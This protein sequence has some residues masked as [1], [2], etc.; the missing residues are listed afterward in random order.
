MQRCADLR[1][2]LIHDDRVERTTNGR[3]RVA[4]LAWDV[5]RRLDAGQGDSIPLLEDLLAFA[6]TV[7]G[8]FLNLEL[9]MP[10]V[11]PATLAALERAG[12]AGPLAI[13]SFDFP[14]LEETRRLDAGVELWLLASKFE[15]V[16]VDRARAIDATCLA[17]EHAAIGPAVVELVAAAG[18]GLVAWT[19]N[20]LVD[21]RRVLALQPVPRAVISNYP[22]RALGVRDELAVSGR[23]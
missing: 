20:E 15:P 19:V 9:K 21:L 5:L 3:G 13:S 11:G 23:A 2:P 16:L 17:L 14:S 1:L 4:D 8:F 10:G 6:P 7:P 12:Y 22:E 18:L